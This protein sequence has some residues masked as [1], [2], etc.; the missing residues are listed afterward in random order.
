MARPRPNTDD[1]FFTFR[2]ETEITRRVLDAE[3]ERILRRLVHFA[4]VNQVWC[5]TAPMDGA[6]PADDKSLMRIAG[7]TRHHWEKHKAAVLS[8]FEA[9]GE[10][11]Y[12]TPAWIYIKGRQ[13]VAA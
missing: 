8:F 10:K 12:L 6:L 13:K 4:A 2:M 11:L 3:A 9:R 1:I 5:D 7:S